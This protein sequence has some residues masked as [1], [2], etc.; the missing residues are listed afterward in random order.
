MISPIKAPII[1]YNKGKNIHPN[2]PTLKKHSGVALEGQNI[3]T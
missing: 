2:T 3:N 1:P